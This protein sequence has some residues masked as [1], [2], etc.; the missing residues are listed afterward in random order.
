MPHKPGHKKIKKLKKGEKREWE[1]KPLPQRPPP[2]SIPRTTSPYLIKKTGQP[3]PASIP[4]PTG[5]PW[6]IKKDT[7]HTFKPVK[8]KYP[9]QP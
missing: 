7:G 4:Y 5:S 1:G 2:A 8:S 6:I 3:P 9:K